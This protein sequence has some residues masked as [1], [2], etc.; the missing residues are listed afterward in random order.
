MTVNCYYLVSAAIVGSAGAGT[1]QVYRRGTAGNHTEE[2][3]EFLKD[4]LR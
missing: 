3:R 1:R 4:V 2:Q